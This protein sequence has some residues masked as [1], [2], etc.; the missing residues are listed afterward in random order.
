MVPSQHFLKGLRKTIKNLDQ[1]SWLLALDMNR[2]TSENEAG[3]LITRT[4]RSIC[5]HFSPPYLPYMHRPCLI[6][7]D[8]ITLP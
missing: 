7:L 1:D 8:L 6:F 4:R 3:T 5:M 2:G